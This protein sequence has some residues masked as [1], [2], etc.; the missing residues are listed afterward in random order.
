M[1]MTT[2]LPNHLRPRREKV[3]GPARGIPLD[4]NA[5]ARLKVYRA[6]LQRQAPAAGPAP[7]PDHPRLLWRCS[8]RCYGA[9]T[10]ARPASASR[11]TRR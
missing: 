1:S 10:T 5:K 6:G 9:S 2:H 8:R 4:G 3:F 11:A 7:R